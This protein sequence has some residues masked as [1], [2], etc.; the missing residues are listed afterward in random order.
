[1]SVGWV[2][3]HKKIIDWEWYT[4]PNM[5]HFFNHLVLKANYKPSKWRGVDLCVGQ[6]LTGRKRLSI[7]TGI[8]ERSIRTCLSNLEKTGEI[9]VEATKAFSIITI[10]NYELYQTENCSSDQP[11]DQQPTNERPTADQQPTTSNKLKKVKEV[12]ELKEKNTQSVPL[13]DGSFFSPSDS[14]LKLWGGA[15]PGV[16]I[17]GELAKLAVW[18][19]SNPSKRKTPKGIK[20]HITAWLS[21]AKK[22]TGDMYAECDF[23]N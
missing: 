9:K 8:S 11:N 2:K 12:K 22:E 14:D 6:L 13:R 7:E 21:S 19:I 23:Q 16:D 20:K 3:N 10:C 4:C 17:D 15:Y 18:N 1:L 5:V